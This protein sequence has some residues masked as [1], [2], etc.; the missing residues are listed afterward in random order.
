MKNFSDEAPGLRIT[1]L[2]W[3]ETARIV[4]EKYAGREHWIA[5]VHASA[6]GLIAEIEEK[7]YAGE[8]DA[9]LTLICVDW[10]GQSY[11]LAAMRKRHMLG[12]QY[13]SLLR[14]FNIR[15]NERELLAKDVM[16]VAPFWLV[17]GDT[18]AL[19]NKLLDRGDLAME[20]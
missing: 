11:Y 17:D 10:R 20:A 2:D 3:E 4:G 7:Y 16:I 5:V 9:D 8:K 13:S 19:V 14:R 15:I 1:P 6:A 18:Q 12:Y